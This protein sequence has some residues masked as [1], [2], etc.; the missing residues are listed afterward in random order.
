MK[1]LTM[2]LTIASLALSACAGRKPNPVAE[3]QNGDATLN[4]RQLA[5][6]ISVNNQAI[7]GLL[8]EKKKKQGNNAAAG[9]VGAVVFFPALFFL[10]LKGATG[11]EARAYQ[12]RNAG[13]VQRYRSKNCKPAIKTLT[14]QQAEAA[15]AK[16]EAET[17]KPAS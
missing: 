16:K 8:D 5:Q 1:T 17:A 4:C 2:T 13:L 12:R 7:L 10:D 9:V 14:E 3:I 11:E 6:E 15:K